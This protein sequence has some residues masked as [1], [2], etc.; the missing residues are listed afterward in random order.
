MNEQYQP[1]QE[2]PRRVYDDELVTNSIELAA[3][4]ERGIDDP[5]S[6]MIATMLHT[7]QTSA[8]H[9]F[10]STGE[11]IPGLQDE[12]D[13]ELREAEEADAEEIAMWMRSLSAY[14]AGRT[15]HEAVPGW[16][17][18][19][20][21][22]PD[23]DVCGT[24]GQHFSEP[25]APGCPADPENEEPSA[26]LAEAIAQKFRGVTTS[27]LI[28]RM[29]TAE[30][31]GYD[32]EEVELTRRLADEGKTWRWSEDFFNPRVVIEGGE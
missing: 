26:E 30:D 3:S 14:V 32:D 7:G 25:H 21:E 15:T 17:T 2:Q 22:Q 6:R 27:E 9:A 4:Q 24:C 29:E 28:R 10:A 5:T 18:L 13:R 20:L 23:D 1:D 19:W 31:F 12:I 11:I 16:S 8:M